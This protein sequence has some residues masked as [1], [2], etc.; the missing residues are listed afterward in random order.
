[1]VAGLV[2]ACTSR[3]S[4]DSVRSRASAALHEFAAHPRADS[5]RP[6][7]E[8]TRGSL[9]LWLDDRAGDGFSTSRNGGTPRRCQANT[10]AGFTKTT[11]GR[12]PLNVC[13]NHS[14]SMRSAA[15]RHSRGRGDRFT[16]A[17]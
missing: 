11:A 15:V 6:F 3:R 4:T 16:I 8:S 10:V 1:M 7:D 14:L 17:N 13:D 9:A 12:Q 2:G 5:Q